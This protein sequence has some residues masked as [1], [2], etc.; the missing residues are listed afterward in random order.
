MGGVVAVGTGVEVGWG[1]IVGVGVG[2]AADV[3]AAIN[4]AAIA[5]AIIARLSAKRAA[6]DVRKAGCKLW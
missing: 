3:Q 4:A 2:C 6:N 1:S 5:I